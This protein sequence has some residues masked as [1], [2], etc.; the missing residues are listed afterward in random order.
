[1][2]YG[3][4]KILAYDGPDAHVHHTTTVDCVLDFHAANIVELF[5]TNPTVGVWKTSKL[6]KFISLNL[7]YTCR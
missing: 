6:L 7:S 1:M 5:F 2:L 3:L 4:E